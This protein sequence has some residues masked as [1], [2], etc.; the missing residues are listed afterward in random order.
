MKYPNGHEFEFKV[1]RPSQIKVDP[2]YQR[3]LETKRVERIVN[4]WNG[5]LVNEPKVSYRDGQYWI[6]NGQHT[7]S[8]WQTKFGDKPILCKLYKGMTWLDECEA[9]IQQNGF[10]KDPSQLE[11]LRAMKEA[12]Y[13]DVTAMV[14]CAEIVG[15]KVSFN[16]QKNT[17][18]TICAISRLYKA[19]MALGQVDFLDMLTAIR[20]SWPNDPD[21]VDG[22]II[23]AMMVFYKTYGGNFKR[24]DLTK[25]L[26][27]VSPT[28]I[29]RN[30]R[31]T[32]KRN[33]FARE[34]VKCYNAKRRNRLDVELL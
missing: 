1:L 12:R 26:R 2:L 31:I 30:G 20:D 5:D 7:I 9:F 28:E 23:N 25:S 22:R 4:E 21:S 19:Y 32:V 11:K 17:P 14:N 10:S 29:I 24:A 15:F 27:N 6:F 8:A 13:T 18:T 16:L 33:G 34:I 3:P